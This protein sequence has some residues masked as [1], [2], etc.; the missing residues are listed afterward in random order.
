[1]LFFILALVSVSLGCSLRQQAAATAIYGS[2]F[3]FPLIVDVSSTDFQTAKFF[4]DFFKAKSLPCVPTGNCTSKVASLMSFFDPAMVG[5]VDTTLGWNIDQNFSL[6]G[7]N[8]YASAYAALKAVFSTYAPYWPATSWSYPSKIVGTLDGG[9][10]VHFTDM[11]YLFGGEIR[12][13]GQVSLNTA[14]TKIVRWADTWDWRQFNNSFALGH[15]APTSLYLSSQT[16]NVP[17]RV[18]RVVNQL[19]ANLTAGNA[20][21]VSQLFSFDATF[22]DRA[23][24]AVIIGRTFI[25]DYFGRALPFLPYGSG[26]SLIRVSGGGFT[27]KSVGD[28]VHHGASSIELDSSGSINRLLS[29]WDASL[30]PSAQLNSLIGATAPR[31]PF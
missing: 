24:N 6:L 2:S 4:L 13:I 3:P 30:L 7:G 14:R 28:V 19:I 12:I 22:E 16:D 11:Q 29:V 20:Y 23:V 15:T 31:Y 8:P 18:T 21:A 5:Y 1:L 17:A 26:V 25:Q 10:F 27:W 9:V